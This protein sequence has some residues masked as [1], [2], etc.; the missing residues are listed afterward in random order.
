MEIQSGWASD[1]CIWLISPEAVYAKMGSSIARGICCMSHIRAWWSSA[2]TTQIIALMHI[3]IWLVSI[4]GKWES[5]LHHISSKHLEIKAKHSIN[6]HT[7]RPMYKGHHRVT[8]TCPIRPDLGLDKKN[9]LLARSIYWG[10]E[11][12]PSGLI[13]KVIGLST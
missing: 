12:W 4:S 5:N 3:F 2:E 6:V 7:M 1:H 10:L 11:R 13:A 9:I 8:K